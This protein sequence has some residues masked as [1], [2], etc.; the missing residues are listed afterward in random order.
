MESVPATLFFVQCIAQDVLWSHRPPKYV[1][2]KSVNTE[3]TARL[4]VKLTAHCSLVKR[5]TSCVSMYYLLTWRFVC[6]TFHWAFVLKVCLVIACFLQRYD[7]QAS[8]LSVLILA[9]SILT[10]TTWKIFWSSW[11]QPVLWK[12]NDIHFFLLQGW[13][14]R[15]LN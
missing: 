14:Q 10:N 15:E 1:D 5:T 4:W 12:R 11:Q 13:V 9:R 3:Q 7:S 2:M 6:L 8:R